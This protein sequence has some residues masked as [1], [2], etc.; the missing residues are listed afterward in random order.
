MI[1]RLKDDLI[2]GGTNGR[3]YL[4]WESDNTPYKV[5]EVTFI[6][7]NRSGHAFAC[8]EVQYEKGS[9]R[10]PLHNNLED[11]RLDDKVT[12]KLFS[13]GKFRDKDYRGTGM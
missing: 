10:L 1:P 7:R 11:T 13:D 3:I 5:H 9:A 2:N 12:A 6:S 4:D 8:L